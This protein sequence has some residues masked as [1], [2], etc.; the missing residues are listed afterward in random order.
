MK[1]TADC[2]VDKRGTLGDARGQGVGGWIKR[3]RKSMVS[4]RKKTAGVV[5]EEYGEDDYAG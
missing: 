1:A 2:G 3:R 4:R 5:V